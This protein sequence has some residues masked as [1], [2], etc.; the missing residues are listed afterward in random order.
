MLRPAGQAY[1][2]FI[3]Q[4]KTSHLLLMDSTIGA[5]THWQDG[6]VPDS[7]SVV[8]AAVTVMSGPDPHITE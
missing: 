3:A 4:A 1:T 8:P 6:S 2:Y 7:V 5:N